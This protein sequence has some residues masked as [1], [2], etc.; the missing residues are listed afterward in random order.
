MTTS[1]NGGVR[2]EFVLPLVQLQLQ[3]LS[4]WRPA[5][6]EDGCPGDCMTCRLCSYKIRLCQFFFFSKPKTTVVFEHLRASWSSPG[7]SQ[8]CKYYVCREMFSLPGTVT[9]FLSFSPRTIH[10]GSGVS[11]R[12]HTR[13][14]PS[15]GDCPVTNDVSC[16]FQSAVSCAPRGEPYTATIHQD[17]ILITTVFLTFSFLSDE[18]VYNHFLFLGHRSTVFFSISA[19][20]LLQLTTGWTSL[21]RVKYV[22]TARVMWRLAEASS[23][24]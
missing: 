24:H 1:A 2:E 3:T 18:H 21:I 16:S 17:F 20:S 8:R 9:W 22:L 7:I 23:P 10:F 5:S 14:I 6:W 19:L 12:R 4:Y 11:F 13:W 15:L